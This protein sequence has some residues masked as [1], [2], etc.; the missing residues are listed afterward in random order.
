MVDNTIVRDPATDVPKI[1]GSRLQVSRGNT[2][3]YMQWKMSALPRMK[4]K[5]ENALKMRL[6]DIWRR[7]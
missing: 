4:Q 5:K 7:K 3:P 1:P 6:K 2:T